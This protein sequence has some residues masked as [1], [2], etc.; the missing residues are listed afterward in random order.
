MLRENPD[1]FCI[2]L[3]LVRRH[4]LDQPAMA[5]EYTLA[6]KSGICPHVPQG[7]QRRVADLTINSSVAIEHGE[8]VNQP[9]RVVTDRLSGPK[10]H[11]SA[12]SR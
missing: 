6:G 12:F 2:A 11:R 4:S 9:F 1:W 3:I 8:S 7:G 10:A 5:L